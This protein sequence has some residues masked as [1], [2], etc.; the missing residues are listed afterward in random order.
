MLHVM[1]YCLIA[2][3]VGALIFVDGRGI[4]ARAGDGK[5]QRG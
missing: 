2:F 5:Q 1:A 3:G 4:G